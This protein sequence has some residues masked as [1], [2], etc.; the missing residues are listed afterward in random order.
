MSSEIV[1]FSGPRACGK[2]T[3]A[4]YLCAEY[5]YTRIAFADVVRSIA[6]NINPESGNDRLFLAKV[7][8]ALRECV[9]DFAILAIQ[10]TLEEIEGSV[11]IEDV[12]F[13]LELK[14]CQEIGAITVRFEIDRDTQVQRLANRGDDLEK[15]NQLVECQDEV[16]FENSTDWDL[17]ISAVGDFRQ[18]A[19]RIHKERRGGAK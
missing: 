7:G 5:G 14:F 18:I 10:R 12:R 8:Q 9:P 16:H 1:A 17:K 13:P 6:A 11:V 15:I 4:E 3:I 2:S 19:E